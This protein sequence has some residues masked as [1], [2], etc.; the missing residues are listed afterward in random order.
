MES[1]QYPPSGLGLHAGVQ[2]RSPYNHVTHYCE[3]MKILVC[4]GRKFSNRAK[5]EH[6]LF[7]V[8]EKRGITLIIEGGANGADRMAREW[9]NQN[10]IPCVTEF[11]DWNRYG[12]A[13]G[14]IRN[15]MMIKNHSPDGVVAFA[16]G[17][18]TADMIRQSKNAGIK[19]LEVD[20]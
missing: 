13:A 6:V 14:P 8:H 4:G 3:D 1:L 15:G 20:A 16:G 9:A 10:G 11:A 7:S 2:R 19:V 17:F 5:L 12:K 18:G